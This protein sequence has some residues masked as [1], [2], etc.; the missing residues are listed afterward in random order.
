M[1]PGQ[2][3][4][5]N[6]LQ[7]NSDGNEMQIKED[8]ENEENDS[9]DPDDD[10]E[11][12]QYMEDRYR[13][14]DPMLDQRIEAIKKQVAASSGISETTQTQPATS[15]YTG[16]VRDAQTAVND[17]SSKQLSRLEEIL[18]R[19]RERVDNISG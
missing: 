11:D 15:S 4:Q 2:K 1:S 5:M 12:S 14:F 17:S 9:E 19:Q 8:N 18:K 10:Q 16:G 13:E 3:Y 7:N 6:P